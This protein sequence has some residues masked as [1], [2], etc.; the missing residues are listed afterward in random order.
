MSLFTRDYLPSQ[1]ALLLLWLEHFISVAN[2]NLAQTGLTAG[3][4]TALNDL[5]TDLSTALGVQ[6]AAK[7]SAEASTTAKNAAMRAVIAEAR[8]LAQIVQKHPGASEALKNELGLTAPPAPHVPVEPQ[9]PIGLTARLDEVGRVTLTWDRNGNKQGT[10][11]VLETSEGMEDSY[12]M[13]AAVTRA[14]YVDQG[15]TPGVLRWY[16][17]KAVRAGRESA[18]STAVAIYGPG[19]SGAVLQIAA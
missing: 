1:V 3:Q 15:R 11:F 5:Y 12:T 4:V 16:R 10:T 18:F 14:K 7:A 17:V 19:N 6:I 2:A 9:L 8:T 13:L